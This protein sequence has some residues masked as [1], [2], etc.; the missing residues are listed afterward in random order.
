MSFRFW[1]QM[2]RE[3][4]E[5]CEA[6]DSFKPTTT[7]GAA[8]PFSENR[9]KVHILHHTSYVSM[10][11]ITCP[12]DSHST[13][14]CVPLWPSCLCHCPSYTTSAKPSHVPRGHSGFG[15]CSG[16][17]PRVAGVVE[18]S[19]RGFGIKRRRKPKA[20]N[21]SFSWVNELPNI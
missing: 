10:K 14:V 2:E 19:R 6:F 8:L 20:V 4:F 13:Y 17:V 1:E 11:I 5:A 12:G 18:T 9:W 3:Y 16:I 15:L 7:S 21:C